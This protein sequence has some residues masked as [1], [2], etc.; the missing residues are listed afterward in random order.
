MKIGFIPSNIIWKFIV[1]NI[2][3]LNFLLER[4]LQRNPAQTRVG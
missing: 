2:T 3:F 1:D 4:K